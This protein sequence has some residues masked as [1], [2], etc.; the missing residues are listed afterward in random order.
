MARLLGLD[1]S[2]T[3]AR[4]VCCCPLASLRA[5]ELACGHLLEVFEE[6]SDLS[7]S[8]LLIACETLNVRSDD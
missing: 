6:L 4:S 8:K 3:E 2:S 5:P 7:F 1:P